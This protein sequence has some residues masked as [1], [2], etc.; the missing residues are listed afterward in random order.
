MHELAIAESIVD[1]VET[2]AIACA[3]TRVKRVRLRIGA[4]NAVVADSLTFC[5]EMLTSELPLLAG[6]LLAIDTLPHRAWCL[7]CGSE[8]DVKDYIAL[9]PTCQEWS[10]SIIS[11]TEFQIMEMEIETA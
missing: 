2:R 6:A 5:F 9:C 4:A 3:A 10:R 7:H 1:A 8:F 11:G